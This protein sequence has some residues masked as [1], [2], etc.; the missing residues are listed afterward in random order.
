V[1]KIVTTPPNVLAPHWGNHRIRYEID[2]LVLPPVRHKLK[3]ELTAALRNYTEVPIVSY[4]D[5]CSAGIVAVRIQIATPPRKGGIDYIFPSLF[6]RAFHH[7]LRH[8]ETFYIDER[9]RTW[10]AKRLGILL[11]T[12]VPTRTEVAATNGHAT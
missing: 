11:P 3:T 12:R 6:R 4:A 9:A 1:E 8:P 5:S 2:R 7:T 10:L